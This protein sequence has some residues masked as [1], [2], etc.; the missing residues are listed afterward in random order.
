MQER[1]SLL[2]SLSAE[3]RKRCSLRLDYAP[4]LRGAPE[5]SGAVRRRMDEEKD[6]KP[7]VLFDGT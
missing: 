5:L 1:D 2:N 7:A 3:W 6:R 4:V